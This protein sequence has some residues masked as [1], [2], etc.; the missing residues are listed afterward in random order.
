[1]ELLISG[2]VM[3][4]L[5]SLMVPRRRAFRPN[6]ALDFASSQMAAL[7]LRRCYSLGFC[8]P[9]PTHV[10]RGAAGYKPPVVDAPLHLG[11]RGHAPSADGGVR[12]QA[13]ARA[14][15]QLGSR[16]S[17]PVGASGWCRVWLLA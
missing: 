2:A 12:H 16:I 8:Y 15:R 4:S 13:K 9:T 5:A 10:S 7:K 6:V 3:L 11:G 17:G 14:R 1:M